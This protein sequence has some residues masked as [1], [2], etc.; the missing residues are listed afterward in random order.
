VRRPITLL[1]ILPL[2][3]TTLRPT[4]LAAQEI[5]H[6][7][8]AEG[9]TQLIV[10]GRPFVIFGGELG[11]SSAGTTGQADR[12]LPR[13]ARTHINTVLMPV[14]WEQMEP[15]EG[16]FDFTI[17]D[18]WIE[19]ATAASPSCAV[20]VRQLE[21]RLLQLRAR[22]GEGGRQAF[23]TRD[24]L[25]GPFAGNSFHT[26]QGEFAGRRSRLSRTDAAFEGIRRAAADRVDGTG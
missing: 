21:E 19:Q 15:V 23:S 10:G 26:I 18:H 3:F 17:L 22:L 25:R 8:R 7:I 1:L 2:V 6:L 13:V 24:F 5:P 9:S 11:N 12:I 16:N 14:A 4:G 20:M